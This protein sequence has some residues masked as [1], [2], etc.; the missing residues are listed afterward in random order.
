[1]PIFGLPNICVIIAVGFGDIVLT[2][3]L[4]RVFSIFYNTFGIINLGLA[5]S[6]TRETI[7]E[8]CIPCDQA[9]C[10]QLYATHQPFAHLVIR[11]LLSQTP[12]RTGTS[13]TCPGPNPGS[14]TNVTS[15][16]CTGLCPP[17]ALAQPGHEHGPDSTDYPC[18]PQDW[19]AKVD[20]RV[21]FGLDQ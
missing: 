3:T 4:G 6:T 15:D 7:I 2:T 16:G 13:Q 8:V 9:G 14:G 10:I 1:M 20:S 11:K 19:R 5:V 12:R 18:G 21:Y 17:S